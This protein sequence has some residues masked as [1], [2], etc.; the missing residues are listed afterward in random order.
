M[1]RAYVAKR[2]FNL[3]ATVDVEITALFHT[4]LHGSL[5]DLLADVFGLLQGEY[6]NVLRFFIQ[7]G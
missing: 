3:K 1:V 5:H 2:Y 4:S 7:K 6:L